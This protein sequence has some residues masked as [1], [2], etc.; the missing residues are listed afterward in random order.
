M[1]LITYLIIPLI[2]LLVFLIVFK[3][4]FK[5]FKYFMI[6]FI[7]LIIVIGVSGYFIY[8]DAVSLA[9]NFPTQNKLI[10]INI[11]KIESGFIISTDEPIFLTQDKVNIYNQFY[12]NGN[13]KSI[14][15]NNYKLII[16]K[17]DK[18]EFTDQVL[19]Y[20]GFMLDKVL[21][22]ETIKS[23]DPKTYLYNLKF[24]D[25]YT[26]QDFDKQINVE[27][28]ELKSAFGLLLFMQEYKKN[29]VFFIVKEFK[30]GNIIVYPETAVFK[31][32]KILPNG[33]INDVLNKLNNP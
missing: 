30:K 22:L 9:N 20:Q 21:V 15:E 28:I 19:D 17:I 32:I 6:A 16:L 5:I 3:F 18:I 29:G 1:A 4:V 14:L 25:R 12:Q 8:R 33:F 23:D 31:L 26:K 27:N 11:D 24:S 13:Y 7:L 2:I 10:L